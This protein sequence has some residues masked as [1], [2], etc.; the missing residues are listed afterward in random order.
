[1]EPD[2]ALPPAVV[3]R[4]EFSLVELRYVQRGDSVSLSVTDGHSGSEIVLDS[5]ELES[6]ARAPHEAFRQLLREL[7]ADHDEAT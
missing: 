7:D 2:T 1:M 5:T 3:L 6:L 4:N